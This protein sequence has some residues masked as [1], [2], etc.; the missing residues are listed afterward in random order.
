MAH[1][2]L[3]PQAGIFEPGQED[4][5]LAA[6]NNIIHTMDG[7][8]WAAAS[9]PPAPGLSLDAKRRLGFA[10]RLSEIPAAERDPLV[11]RY[12]SFKNK[13]AEF[14]SHNEELNTEDIDNYFAEQGLTVK[15]AIVLATDE[16]ADFYAELHELGY[17]SRQMEDVIK[18][19][20]AGVPFDLLG[21]EAFYAPALERVVALRPPS[22]LSDHQRFTI[23][24]N[25]VH[26]K[27]HSTVVE[28]D[29]TRIYIGRNE[30][31]GAGYAQ[32]RGGFAMRLGNYTAGG[33]KGDFLE[34][35]YADLSA[36]NYVRSRLGLPHGLWRVNE[37][38]Q[39]KTEDAEALP[40]EYMIPDYESMTVSMPKGALAAYGLELISQRRP[41][42][43]GALN[44]ARTTVDGLRQVARTIE[45]VQPGLYT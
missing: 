29:E 10:V 8:P 22:E 14:S 23:T 41:E 12:M 30:R 37:S 38:G 32:V 24:Y 17:T 42:L 25:L 7:E 39:Y 21:A 34:E 35:G 1:E 2:S 28:F 13:A 45:G 16:I 43:L 33:P 5:T 9:T 26:E 18:K 40:Y 3:D 44:D 36:V 31:H 6:I 19:I 27:A 11:L 4:S 15:P 20:K